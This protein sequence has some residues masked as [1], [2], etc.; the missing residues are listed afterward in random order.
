MTTPAVIIYSG[1]NL[2]GKQS[3]NRKNKGE[4]VT[5]TIEETRAEIKK[6]KKALKDGET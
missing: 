6:Q 3:A 1:R 4:V 2:P 5:E